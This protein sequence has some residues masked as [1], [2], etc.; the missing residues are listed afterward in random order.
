LG[1]KFPDKK[2][3]ALRGRHDQLRRIF[4]MLFGLMA[5]RQREDERASV[6]KRL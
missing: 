4:L 6:G 2:R 1:E 5:H 3:V